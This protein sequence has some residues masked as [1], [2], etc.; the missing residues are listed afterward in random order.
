MLL[1]LASLPPRDG[2]GQVS[3]LQRIMSKPIFKLMDIALDEEDREYST[4][5][6]LERRVTYLVKPP[7]NFFSKRIISICICILMNYET[8]EVH[9]SCLRINFKP[10]T[11]DRSPTSICIYNPDMSKSSSSPSSS[12]SSEESCK[13][14]SS[15]R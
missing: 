4:C 5:L 2:G 15:R 3:E 10:T 8:E 7:L 12:S 6:T 9:I 13:K 14:S 11:F 1:D